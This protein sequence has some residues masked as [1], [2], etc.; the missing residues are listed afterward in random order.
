MKHSRGRLDE[1]APFVR[2]GRM[3]LDGLD[4]V[5]LPITLD[6]AS[7]AGSLDIPHKDPF[8]RMLIAQSLIEKV[9]IVSNERLFESFAVDRIW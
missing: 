3:V 2:K 1:A 5:P 8:D 6:H 9:P 4:F 7:L